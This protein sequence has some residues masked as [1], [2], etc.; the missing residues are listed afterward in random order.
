ML[1]QKGNGR[2]GSNPIGFSA[3]GM[4][5]RIEAFIQ[6]RIIVGGPM[7]AGEIFLQKAN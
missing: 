7:F 1:K 3:C 5:G 2:V 6:K 4:T